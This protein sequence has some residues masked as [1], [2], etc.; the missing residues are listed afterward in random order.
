VSSGNERLL[1]SHR[2]EITVTSCDLR[3]F[4]AF[5]ERTE[6]E[7]VMTVLREYHTALGALIEKFG[8]TLEHF[9]G[10]SILVL[11][12][13]PLPCD[14]PCQR[15][16]RMA[17]EM[18][19]EMA[20]LSGKW[21]KLGHELGFGIGISHG[22][23]T[24]GCIGFAGRLQYSATGSVANLACRLCAEAHDGQILIDAKVHGVTDGLVTVESAGDL[25][26]K[27]FRW[28]VS[29][30]SVGGLVAQPAL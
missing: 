5:A 1:E 30:F 14:D 27:G 13:D 17:V 22:Y 6:P 20:A 15:A 29:A 11:F 25:T 23:A 12:N 19:D 2:R 10:D 16:V 26:L 8:G 9:A 21:R 4:T 7:E 3:G 24:L 28:P 18:R